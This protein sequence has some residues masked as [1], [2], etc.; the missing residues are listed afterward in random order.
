MVSQDSRA[1]EEGWNFSGLSPS[2]DGD[3]LSFR[4][5]ASAHSTWCY[6]FSISIR[7]SCSSLPLCPHFLGFVEVHSSK[8]KAEGLGL[9]RSSDTGQVAD[10]SWHQFPHP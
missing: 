1:F 4:S 2:K 6:K 8:P 5:S 10:F 9:K 3:L 7:G